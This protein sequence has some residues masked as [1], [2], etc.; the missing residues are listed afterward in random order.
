MDPARPG[1]QKK[2]LT[3]QQA[4][5]SLAVSIDVLLGWN[6]HNILKPTITQTGEIGYTQEQINQFLAI[7]QFSQNKRDISETTEN[8]MREPIFPIDPEINKTSFYTNFQGNNNFLQNKSI[9][10]N[11][12]LNIL[13]ISKN[14]DSAKMSS[15][16]LITFFSVITISI[17][18]ALFTQ[19][20]KIKLL[21]DRSTLLSEKEAINIGKVLGSQTSKLNLS[22]PNSF[23]PSS[24]Q[25]KNKKISYGN[26]DENK[27][28]LEN[29]F[30]TTAAVFGKKVVKNPVNDVK[31]DE[32]LAVM[33]L[34]EQNK[35]TNI[36]NLSGAGA[37][38]ISYSEI[39]NFASSSSCPS[40]SAG[41]D[42]ESDLV[43]DTA[44]NIK[45]NQEKNSTTS[46]LATTFGSTGIIQGDSSFKQVIDPSI[47]LGFFAFS[48]LSIFLIF[49]KQFAYFT[50]KTGATT[51]TTSN[52]ISNIEKQKLLEVDQK[53]DGTVVLYF[54]GKEYKISKPELDSE[55]D[56]FINRLMELVQPNVKEIDYDSLKDEKISLNTP[57]STLVTRLGFVGIKRDLFFP[58]TS[59]NKVLFR[60]FVT[61]Q[62]LISMNLTANQILGNF[63]NF[64]QG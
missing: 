25:F 18:I 20:D 1:N 50:K 47:T 14:T 41:K 15:S 35:K 29:K 52:I 37:E 51:T 43:F 21:I 38:I 31:T 39:S 32:T 36:Q 30:A 64:S 33:P 45:E 19:Q 3:L 54:Q 34:L 24:V 17:L 23:A 13:N 42:S 48:L 4:A 59:K 56:Q 55:S 11:S 60:R 9:D 62:D 7:Y 5:Q 10:V 6:E 63:A 16:R 12:D 49:K 27:T 40:C 53:T 61:E 28:A 46:F 26:L 2:L 8:P 22:K 58:R 44:G 57:L